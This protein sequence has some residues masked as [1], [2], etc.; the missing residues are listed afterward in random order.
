MDLIMSQMK[1]LEFHLSKTLLKA[2]SMPN[3]NVVRSTSIAEAVNKELKTELEFEVLYILGHDTG[4]NEKNQIERR[5][6]VQW[7]GYPRVNQLQ[8]IPEEN[9]YPNCTHLLKLYLDFIN[10]KGNPLFSPALRKELKH[11]LRLPTTARGLPSAT[12]VYKR[13]YFGPNVDF[14]EN[15]FQNLINQ[16]IYSDKEGVKE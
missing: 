10:K 14:I 2:Q 9:F 12:S 6:L 4:V 16:N 7:K 11:S 3:T 15:Y 1:G 13:E 5:Y 8:F